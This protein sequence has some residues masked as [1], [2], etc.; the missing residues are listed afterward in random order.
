MTPQ[1]PPTDRPLTAGDWIEW[2]GGENPVPGQMVNWQTR[3]RPNRDDCETAV[4]SNALDWSHQCRRGFLP[5]IAYRLSRPA[6]S[7]A[8]ED[9]WSPV[10]VNDTVQ[11]RL[12]DLGRET[13]KAYWGPFSAGNYRPVKVDGDGWAEF[14]LWDLMAVFGPKIRMGMDV[15]FETTIRVKTPA[16]ASPP[17][18]ERERELEG[19]LRLAANRLDRL[20]LEAMFTPLESEVAEWVEEVRRTLTA[21]PAGERK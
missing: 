14:Q 18:S 4:P 8:S 15:P 6:T 2:H 11:V 7:A 10:N 17:V 19:A 21:N 12:T 16:L 9:G 5:I 20:A 1:T 13:H 3:N